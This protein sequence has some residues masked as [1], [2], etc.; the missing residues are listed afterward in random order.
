MA[1]TR[2]QVAQSQRVYHELYTALD[3]ELRAQI[4]SA[5]G[6]AH[7]VWRWLKDKFQG[8]QA[9]TV[10]QLL[11][12]W[13]D[14]AQE[15]GESIDAYRARVNR[16][17]ALLVAAKEPPSARMYALILLGKLQPLYK[18]VVQAQEAAGNLK[19]PESADWDAIVATF[20]GVDRLSTY[21]AAQSILLAG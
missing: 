21:F 10:N 7:G 11:Q 15:E 17:R 4:P 5:A 2:H 18:H 19:A 3:V 6:Y 14:T 12:Q 16:M 20:R 8:T 13:N 1:T 9:D